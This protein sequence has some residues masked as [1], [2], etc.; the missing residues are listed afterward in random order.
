MNPEDTLLLAELLKDFPVRYSKE[1]I[2]I[3]PKFFPECVTKEREAGFFKK[4]IFYIHRYPNRWEVL[5]LPKMKRYT[6][7]DQ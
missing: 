4:K 5:E 6:F 2:K 3:D 7:I 1:V